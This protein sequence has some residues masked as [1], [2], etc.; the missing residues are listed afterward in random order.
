MSQGQGH[1]QAETDRQTRL[2]V[3]RTGRLP[4]QYV[5]TR[6]ECIGR[7][8]DKTGHILSSPIRLGTCRFRDSLISRAESKRRCCLDWAWGLPF[9]LHFPRSLEAGSGVPLISLTATAMATGASLTQ[10][11][12]PGGCDS[13]VAGP[14]PLPDSKLSVVTTRLGS[15]RSDHPWPVLSQTS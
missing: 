6:C 4:E 3:G 2:A 14:S 1:G 7:F 15:C 13:A 9:G 11:C 5:K 8:L 10:A 12:F